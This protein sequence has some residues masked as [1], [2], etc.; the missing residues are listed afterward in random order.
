MWERF[1]LAEELTNV[2]WQTSASL[3]KTAECVRAPTD[4][5]STRRRSTYLP[6]PP[7]AAVCRI[8]VVIVTLR[9]A[10]ISRN[11]NS[12]TYLLARAHLRIYRRKF[13]PAVCVSI[14]SVN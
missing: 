14:V 4:R 11:V 1:L 13:D 5:I 9:Y 6:P 2:S 7:P 10:S 3:Y 8:I 12:F